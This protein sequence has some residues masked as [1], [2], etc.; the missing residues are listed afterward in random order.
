MSKDKLLAILDKQK[1]VDVLVRKQSSM[2]HDRVENVVLKQH[3][4]ELLNYINTHSSFEVAT[5]LEQ[6]N[7]EQAQWVW[8]K[9]P[10]RKQ[11]EILWELSN[12]RRALLAQ[13][14]EP[15]FEKKMSERHICFEKKIQG[16]QDT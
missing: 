6:I 12:E 11:N 3:D 2:H 15:D 4:A 13:G 14:K 7:I 9:I 5:A 8:D 10:Q 1:L 16:E